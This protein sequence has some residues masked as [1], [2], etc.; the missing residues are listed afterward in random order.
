MN[1]LVFLDVETTGLDPRIHQPYELSWWREDVD[2][3][4]TAVLPHT[5]EYADAAALKI[6]GYFERG[7]APFG[8]DARQLRVAA[9]LARELRGVTLVGSNPPFDAAM[10]RRVI[11]CDI[12]HHRLIDVSQGAMWVLGLD[13]PPGLGKA[14][15]MLRVLGY[16][17]PE[18]D[19]TAE[20]DV[21]AT[22]AVYYALKTIRDAR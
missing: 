21:R 7:F 12:W 3:P 1:P 8:N 11:G 14:A 6:G 2:R 22:R 13:R 10:I 9:D 5:L 15:E 4:T 19:H 16:D 20:G 18:A 17:I